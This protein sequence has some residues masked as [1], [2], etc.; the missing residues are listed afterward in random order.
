MQCK[1]LPPPLTYLPVRGNCGSCR[2]K[3]P[4]GQGQ[5]QSGSGYLDSGPGST[6][7]KPLTSFLAR[8]RR[9][10]LT[11]LMVFLLQL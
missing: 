11:R 1:V 7:E 8:R 4:Q 10:G 2:K 9:V 5:G 3:T 6:T